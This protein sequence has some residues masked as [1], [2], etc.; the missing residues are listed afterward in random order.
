MEEY[1]QFVDIE[2]VNI[3]DIYCDKICDKKIE[4]CINEFTL[5]KIVSTNIISFF[6]SFFKS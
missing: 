1:G 3:D 4:N 6:G 2:K 5:L